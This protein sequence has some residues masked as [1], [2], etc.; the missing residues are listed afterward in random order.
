MRRLPRL[1]SGSDHW[2]LPLTESAAARL[3]AAWL[4]DDR[5]ECGSVLAELLCEEPTIAL[6]TVCRAGRWSQRPPAG[7]TEIAA[8]LSEHG[9]SHLQWSEEEFGRM[10]GA[11]PAS[12]T[13]WSTLAEESVATAR[14]AARLA[15]E[16]DLGPSFLGGLL[17]NAAR[18]LASCGPPYRSADHEVLPVWL[19]H[20]LQQMDEQPPQSFV[21]GM[22]ARARRRIAGTADPT[23]ETEE[24]ESAVSELCLEAKSV[25]ERW[26]ETSDEL[27]RLLPRLIR[28]LAR[29]QQ[30]ETEFQAALEREKLDALKELAY[31][32]SHEINNPLANIST[33]AQ[34][35]MREETDPERRRKLAVINAQAFRAHEMISDMM[36]FARPP[37]LERKTVDLTALVDRVIAELHEEAVAQGTELIRVTADE[38]VEISADAGY[39]AV[40]LKALCT[41]S[42]EA[43]RRGGRIEVF[44]QPATT[45]PAEETDRR[46]V[47]I[48]V[49][50]TGPGISPEVR[51]HLFDP[52]Y[53]GREAGRGLGLG[54]SKCWRIVTEHGGRIEVASQPGRGTTFTILLPAEAC[55]NTLTAC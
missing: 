37:A 21:P 22:V 50:D 15:G 24:R 18:W 47:E 19:I 25:R 43:L 17:H 20:W 14:C 36:L 32:A 42:L 9:L 55:P 2:Y 35:L 53:S 16:T 38:P 27:G 4:A 30:L 44:V 31:G 3:V 28:K 13:R 1:G 34:T 10:P 41:N 45:G 48:L 11:E 26:R 5:N 23:S 54:L 12:V 7:M 46:W 8:W 6:W 39:L 49:S 29:L 40:A 33:R 52:Y 51:R